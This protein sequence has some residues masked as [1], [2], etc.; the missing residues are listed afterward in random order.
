MFFARPSLTGAALCIILLSA[1]PAFGQQSRCRFTVETDGSA[2]TAKAAELLRRDV[3]R[4]GLCPRPWVVKFS[5]SSQKSYTIALWT[6]SDLE[7]RSTGDADQIVPV[8]QMLLRVAVERAGPPPE[9][10][11]AAPPAAPPPEPPPAPPSQVEPSSRGLIAFRLGPVWSDRAGWGVGGGVEAGL[12]HGLLR[13]SLAPHASWVR[14]SSEARVTVVVPVRLGFHES[15]GLGAFLELGP[16]WQRVGESQAGAPA[17]ARWGLGL[18][19]GLSFTHALG[20]SARWHLA[21]PVRFDLFSTAADDPPAPVT[22][23]PTEMPG[24]G[25]NGNGNNGNNGNGNGNGNDKDKNKEPLTPEALSEALTESA[26]NFGGFSIGLQ[27]GVTLPVLLAWALGTFR[28][29]G[30]RPAK[31][32]RRAG[33]LDARVPKVF[34]SKATTPLTSACKPSFSEDYDENTCR[35]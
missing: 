24:N 15:N 29:D 13:W 4:L 32:S 10:P 27:F 33:G 25:N 20:K 11:P 26:R 16:A 31:N 12:E 23:S 35:C 34:G 28:S 7:T 21:L 14:D 2:E 9:P 18:G 1:E 30:R 8:S 5:Q 3:D 19:G 6:G 22:P 17:D